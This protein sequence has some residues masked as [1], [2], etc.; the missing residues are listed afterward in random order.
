MRSAFLTLHQDATQIG[1]DAVQL[2]VDPICGPAVE[3]QH[4]TH[5][6]GAIQEGGVLSGNSET[7]RKIQRSSG[8]FHWNEKQVQEQ[9]SPMSDLSCS[10]VTSNHPTSSNKKSNQVTRWLVR[11]SPS[12]PL[13]R[14][15]DLLKTC[16]FQAQKPSIQDSKKKPVFSDQGKDENEIEI[17]FFKQIIQTWNSNLP[18]RHPCLPLVNVL[19][20]VDFLGRLGWQPFHR[21]FG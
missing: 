2:Q 16:E 7:G 20:V 10:K 4:H 18:C 17:M 1:R 21:F 12:S 15:Q 14:Y 9:K 3:D 11:W 8:A 5:A 19:P 13:T 6:Q